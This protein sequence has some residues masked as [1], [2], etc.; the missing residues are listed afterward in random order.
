MD[1]IAANRN[2]AGPSGK[3]AVN[4]MNFA[5]VLRQAGLPVGPGHVLDALGAAGCGSLRSRE[6]F[7]WTLPAVFVNRRGHR[8]RSD[9]PLPVFWKKPRILEQLMQVLFNQIT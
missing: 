7:Y 9:Q 4:I 3:F 8:A 6:D 2:D 1:V 5:R